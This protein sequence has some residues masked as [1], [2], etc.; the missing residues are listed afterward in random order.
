MD[1]P[2]DLQPNRCEFLLRHNTTIFQSPITR[3]QQALRRQGE[4]WV[5]TAGFR[6]SRNNAQRMDALLAKLRGAFGTIRIWDWAREEPLGPN[7]D[8]STVP[9]TRFAD[10]GPPTTTTF[11]DGTVFS[12]GSSDVVVFVGQSVGSTVVSSDGWFHD[13]TVLKAGDYVGLAGYLYML[14]EDLVSD[15]VGQANMQIEPGLR[16]DVAGGTPIVRIRPS[17]EVRLVDDDQPNRGTNYDK[18]SYDYTLSFVE[19]R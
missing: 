14:T 2:I 6:F 12:A 8:R 9:D 18:G 7:L 4:Q 3:S 19:A 11:T 10:V 1:W 15:S 13:M 16:A 5:C 17:V